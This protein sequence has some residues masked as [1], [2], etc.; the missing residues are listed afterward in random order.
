M[1]DEKGIIGAIL[2]L[3]NWASYHVFI[4]TGTKENEGKSEDLRTVIFLSDTDH[5]N[6]D[7]IK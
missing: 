7:H 6:M 2:L 5:I 3:A 1:A 4:K